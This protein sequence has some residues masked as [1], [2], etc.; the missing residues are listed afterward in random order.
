LFCYSTSA[1]TKTVVFNKN[2]SHVRLDSC[3]YEFSEKQHIPI[4]LDDAV[5]FQRDGVYTYVDKK[6]P[7]YWKSKVGHWL[8]FKLISHSES[9]L[10]LEINNAVIDELDAYLI[11]SGGVISS[12]PASGWRVPVVSREYHTY[13]NCYKLNLKPNESYELFIRVKRAQ[14]TLKVPII[15]WSESAFYNFLHNESL[16]YGFFSGLI[17]F[18]SIFSFAIYFYLKDKKYLF[19]SFYCISVLFWRLIVEGFALNFFQ[20]YLPHFQNPMWSSVLNVSAAYFS[21]LFLRSFLLNERSPKWQFTFIK[22]TQI[23]TLLFLIP[24]FIYGEKPLNDFFSYLYNFFVFCIILNMLSAIYLGIKQRESNAFIYLLS[25]FPV[26]IYVSAVTVTSFLEKPTPNYL[27]D[28]FLWTLLFE[29]VI[30][31]IGLAINFKK[32]VDEK[33]FVLEQ[34]N[35]KQKESFTMQVKFQE[36]VIKRAEA[37]VELKNEKERISRDL[38]DSIGTD[39][40][41]IIYNIEYVKY[42]FATNKELLAAFDK[43]SLNAKYTMAQLRSAIWVLNNDNITLELFI[44]KLNSHIYRILEDRPE[45]AYH[46]ITNNENRNKI[47]QAK[48]VLNLY[49]VIQESLSNTLKYAKATEVTLDIGFENEQLKLVFSDNGIGFNLDDA[50]TK[51]TF[52]LKNIKKRIQELNGNFTINTGNSGTIISIQIPLT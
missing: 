30:L 17:L 48:F 14:L 7:S 44:N 12:L 16:K 18:I 11:D 24:L 20:T 19:Y 40:S 25:I 52:G 1:N 9:A 34:L 5:K 8:Y 46:L 15:I 31:S 41:N 29:I 33:S 23:G 32:F 2:A 51:E 37:Q 10:V 22:F 35:L 27:Y 38:H 43:L 39:L 6:M 36:E 50:L 45:I 21:M 13:K 26:I 42:E 3:I 47:L 4:S 28:K 49:R